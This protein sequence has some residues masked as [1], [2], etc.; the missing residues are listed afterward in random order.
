[1]EAQMMV[2]YGVEV[3]A[4]VVRPRE[5]WCRARMTMV[6]G[7]SLRRCFVSPMRVGTGGSCTP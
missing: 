5:V 2:P 7:D 6:G 1:M 3:Q 4:L